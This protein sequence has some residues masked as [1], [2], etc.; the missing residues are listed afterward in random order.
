MAIA[1]T[2]VSYDGSPVQLQMDSPLLA[3]FDPPALDL[4]GDMLRPGAPFDIA[5]LLERANANHPA[6]ACFTIADFRP[7]LYTFDPR[8]IKKFGDE[9]DDFSYGEGEQGAG[10]QAPDY[11]WVAV[12]SGTL[13]F[14]DFGRLPKLVTL[15]T[16]EQYDRSLG[17]GTILP[18]IVEELG[19]PHFAV[20]VSDSRLG[21]QF[22]GDGTYTVPAGF[23]KLVRG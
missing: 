8:D 15:L 7:G 4:L 12:D 13:I 23:V 21:I 10:D 9:D 22:D 5:A 11:L 19:G 16:W 3:C 18:A 2:N 20:V 17:D 1:S 14:A 6:V